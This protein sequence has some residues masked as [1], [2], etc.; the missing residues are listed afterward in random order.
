MK[1]SFIYAFNPSPAAIGAKIIRYVQNTDVS[2]SAIMITVGD[3]NHIYES[4][5]PRSRKIKFEDWSHKYQIKRTYTFEVPEHLQANILIDLED[6]MGKIYSIPQILLI[7]FTTSCKLFGKVARHWILNGRHELICTEIQGM[8]I[9]EYTVLDFN[10]SLDGVDLND[11]ESKVI[12]L[13]QL[14]ANN[15]SIWI[16]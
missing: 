7:L 12:K 13:S 16:P 1:I 8:I 11:V 6:M 10:E 14:E 5:W 4:I 3:N 2:H 9:E 15:A